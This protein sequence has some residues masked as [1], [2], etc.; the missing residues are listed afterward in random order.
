[1]FVNR[2]SD[3]LRDLITD[4]RYTEAFGDSDNN[5]ILHQFLYIS[6]CVS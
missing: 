6:K 1:L 5:V 3:E 2:L 4:E